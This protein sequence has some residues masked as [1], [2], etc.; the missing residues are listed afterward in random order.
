MSSSTAGVWRCG[1]CYENG[2]N[3]LTPNDRDTCAQSHKKATSEYGKTEGTKKNDYWCLTCCSAHPNEPE[4]SRGEVEAEK[5]G[6]NWGPN[7]ASNMECEYCGTPFDPCAK[8]VKSAKGFM[9]P[10][11]SQATKMD[12]IESLRYEVW[13]QDH[14]QCRKCLLTGRS[15]RRMNMDNG[16]CSACRTLSGTELLRTRDQGI[17]SRR[18][19]H[20]FNPGETQDYLFLETIRSLEGQAGPS[21]TQRGEA[22]S[23]MAQRN[24]Q[25]DEAASSIANTPSTSAQ[26]EDTDAIGL[27]MP[28][29]EDDTPLNPDMAWNK[30][31][32]DEAQESYAYISIPHDPEDIEEIPEH[33]RW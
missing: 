29:N 33:L 28:S 7:K 12:Q 18:A 5:R 32:E 4:R 23:S 27:V 15:Y 9:V 11:V 17:P 22:S 1:I 13:N 26:W 25:Q 8:S 20:S 24:T 6:E 19:S 14:W 30:S 10:I 3:R 16:T 31:D 2:I 21:R